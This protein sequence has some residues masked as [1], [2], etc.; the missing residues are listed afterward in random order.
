MDHRPP[1]RLGDSE[2]PGSTSASSSAPGAV[3]E[4]SRS[5][6]RLCSVLGACLAAFVLLTVAVATH[7]GGTALDQHVWR[8]LVDHRGG[9]Q[10]TVSR[11]ISHVG[12]PLTLLL[13]AVV[14][15]VWLTR[16]RSMAAGL[17]PVAALL[18]ASVTETAMKQLVGRGRPPAFTR[19]LTETDPSFPSGHTTGTAALLMTIAL[20]AV[21]ALKTR[22]A[23]LVAVLAAGSVAAAV[24]LARMVLGVHWLTDV[25]AGWLL[26]TA[27]AIG[28]TLL[29]PSAER[30]LADR[31]ARTRADQQ[32]ARS[33]PARTSS[34]DAG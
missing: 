28:V 27:W 1:G 31:A 8:W 15:G 34:A 17:A 26:G 19:L 10:V 29:V 16:H 23:R 11:A 3:A 30:H 32:A 13:L 14:A 25:A 18:G 9:P 6:L 33:T 24:G 2:R 4:Q 20:V 22:T 5:R 21:P 12:D 7:L